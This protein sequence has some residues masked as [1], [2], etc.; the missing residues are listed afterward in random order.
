MTGGKSYRLPPHFETPVS[1]QD[2]DMLD[3]S[4]LY[5]TETENPSVKQKKSKVKVICCTDFLKLKVLPTLPKSKDRSKA[6]L[7]LFLG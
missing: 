3:D 6:T 5:E 7:I 2:T 4:I 1:L